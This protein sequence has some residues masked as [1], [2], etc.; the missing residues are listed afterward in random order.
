MS[1]N[2]RLAGATVA[3]SP[4]GAS[5]AHLNTQTPIL[6]SAVAAG[7]ADRLRGMVWGSF[8]GDA[9]AMPGHWYYNRTALHSDYGEIRDYMAPRNPHPGSI[10]WR[11][12]YEAL[13]SRGEILHEQARYWGQRDVHYHQFLKP[14]ENTLN[15][16]LALLFAGLLSRTGRYDASA[17]LAA[18]IDFMTTPGHHSDT[19]VE[20]CHRLFFT[21]YAQGKAPEKCGG[22]DIHIGGLASVAVLCAGAV[23]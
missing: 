12:S 8:I 16:K 2:E 6:K 20:E 21:R 18:Y 3:E 1:D 4:N 7:L 14:G 11:S 15:L 17:Y 9:L 22:E 5:F 19:Y 10:L 23:G 13:N